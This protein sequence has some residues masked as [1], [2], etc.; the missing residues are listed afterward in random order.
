MIKYKYKYTNTNTN[1][2]T[3]IQIQIQGGSEVKFWPLARKKRFYENGHISWPVRATSPQHHSKRSSWRAR[4]EKHLRGS[5][6]CPG[7]TGEPVAPVLGGGT[8]RPIEMGSLWVR[9]LKMTKTKSDLFCS[10]C[11]FFGTFPHTGYQQAAQG[12]IRKVSRTFRRRET[13]RFPEKNPKLS[14]EASLSLRNGFSSK[15]NQ[16]IR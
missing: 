12:C 4:P 1:T 8:D 13:A 15:M 16:N 2:H 3:Q 5:L 7:N 11:P 14:C 10:F 9:R 6:T